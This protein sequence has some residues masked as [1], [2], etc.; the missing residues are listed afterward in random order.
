VAGNVKDEGI[1]SIEE[2]GHFEIRGDKT[3]MLALDELLSSFAKE[4]RMK[5][6]GTVYKPC[7]KVIS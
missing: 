3:M 6:P 2:H 7:Y 1:R 5:L 4:H